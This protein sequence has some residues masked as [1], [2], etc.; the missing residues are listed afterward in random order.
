MGDDIDVRSFRRALGNFATGVTVV[1]AQNTLGQKVGVTANSFNSVSLD[2]PLVLWS[3]AKESRSLSVFE[4]ASHFAVNIL[5]SDQIELS[6]HFSQ[7][8]KD[9]FAAVSWEA[10]IGEC[11]LLPDCAGRFQC[12]S[13]QRIDAGDHWIFLGKVVAFD[14]Y[15]G[16]PLCYHQGSYSIVSAHP[17]MDKKAGQI[18]PAGMPRGRLRDNVYFLMLRALNVYQSAYLPKQEALGTSISEARAIIL[19]SDSPELFADGIP[20]FANAPQSEVIEILENLSDRGWLV[21]AGNGY[22]LTDKGQLK[23]AQLWALADT[24]ED[25]IFK[26]LSDQEMAQYKQI[27]RNVGRNG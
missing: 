18:S 26:G 17:G 6:N 16:A 11:P 4:S 20:Q 14:D 1:T 21:Q 25:T 19:L 3:L 5:A 22:A 24:Q 7:N 9:K 15:G 2:P 10:G 8:Q 13:Y 23:A 12:E 27:L